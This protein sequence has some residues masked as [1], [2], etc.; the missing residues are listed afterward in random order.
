[1]IL[2]TD[3]R[4]TVATMVKKCP[5]HSR[6]SILYGPPVSETVKKKKK[7]AF[8][9]RLL[10]PRNAFNTGDANNDNFFI[11]IFF[12]T[13]S[14][15]PKLD[16]KQKDREKITINLFRS[17]SGTTITA[18]A[19]NWQTPVKLYFDRL[20]SATTPQAGS[21]I[22]RAEKKIERYTG[23]AWPRSIVL[24]FF[25]FFLMRFRSF[26]PA[27]HEQLFAAPLFR[28]CRRLSVASVIECARTISR[29][30]IHFHGNAFDKYA[31]TSF[32][33]VHLNVHHQMRTPNL[34]RILRRPQ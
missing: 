18:A 15:S 22:F 19:V 11:I 26:R 16:E 8:S 32:V 12:T 4:F 6:Y 23:G 3:T 25:C 10:N 20:L 30:Q 29:K 5:G 34:L 14:P 1:M 27:A 7:N 31:C 21:W 13:P 33:H 28:L 17:W 2:Y 9:R 24:V